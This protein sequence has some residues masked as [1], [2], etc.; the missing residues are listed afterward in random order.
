MAFVKFNDLD[1]FLLLVIFSPCTSFFFFFPLGKH[2]SS[3]MFMQTCLYVL[4]TSL[5]WLCNFQ[6]IQL[7]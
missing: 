3:S 2:V 7:F 5:A 1:L 4:G 6:E